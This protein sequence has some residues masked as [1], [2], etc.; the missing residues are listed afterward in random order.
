MDKIIRDVYYNTS[1]P[2]CFA[3]VTA[4]LRECKRRDAGIKLKDVESFLAKQETY[5]LHKPTRRRFKR[6]VTTT[7][8]ID[9]DWQSDLADMRMLKQDN[10]GFTYIV[11]CVDVL[12]RYGFAVPVKRKTPDLVADAFRTI[13]TATG[14]KP[15]F[16]TTDRGLEYAGKSFQNFVRKED[17]VHKFA[18]SPDV[19]CAIAERYIRT[20]KSR[21]WR[22]F[23]R[24]KTKRYIDVLPD[25]VTALNKSFHRTIKRAP[26]D[27]TRENQTEVW[28]VLYGK[29]VRKPK[30]R[31]K[32]GEHVRIAIEK[33]VL[34]K[35]YRPNYSNEIFTVARVMKQRVP[36]TY[37]LKD[38]SG[39]EIEGIFYNEELVR[40]VDDEK[41]VRLIQSLKKSERRGEELWHLIKWKDSKKETW[42]RNDELISI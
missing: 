23:T 38:E 11:V 34:S 18:T 5:T 33:H 27:V 19:K 14:R 26:K 31:F 10:D 40:V 41:P 15:W 16:L 32:S 29:P 25:L 20:L 24:N 35:G 21:L 13:I 6:N 37:K 8:G 7:A 22:Y 9:V 36:A 3:G 2:A 28:Q 39:E 17:I 42:I 12:S 1:S 30:Y 4:V